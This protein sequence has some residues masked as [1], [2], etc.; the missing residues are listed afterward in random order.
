LVL[1]PLKKINQCSKFYLNMRTQ[2]NMRHQPCPLGSI[3]PVYKGNNY[4]HIW[5]WPLGSLHEVD[6]IEIRR[7]M[8]SS[9]VIGY[10][11]YKKLYKYYNTLDMP[12]LS[13]GAVFAK[14]YAHFHFHL[15]FS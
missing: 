13:I 2:M 14:K 8:K 12:D 1:L 4:V 3:A 10:K 7:E 11:T 9:W 15:N 6:Y 5:K